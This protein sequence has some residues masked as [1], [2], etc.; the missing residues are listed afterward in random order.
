MRDI[1][2]DIAQAE[3]DE[4][5]LRW[6]AQAAR[7]AGRAHWG[8]MVDAE[9]AADGL[10]EYVEWLRRVRR[11]E[12]QPQWFWW[13]G[14]KQLDSPQHKGDGDAAVHERRAAAVHA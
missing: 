7:E 2:A 5:L 13:L 12:V 14:G 10:A 8:L 6:L 11:G 3:R 4:T 1:D 9:Q